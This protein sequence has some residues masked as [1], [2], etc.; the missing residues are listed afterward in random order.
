MTRP[1]RRRRGRRGN[2]GGNR[3][4]RQQRR[5]ERPTDEAVNRAA[6]ASR[7]GRG[8]CPAHAWWPTFRRGRSAHGRSA[9]GPAG[10]E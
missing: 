7:R 1:Q 8:A 6:H 3:S 10:L 5:E 9:H 4:Q 2:R